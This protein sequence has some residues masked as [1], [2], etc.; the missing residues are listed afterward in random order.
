MA[1]VTEELIVLFKS[2]GVGAAAADMEKMALGSGKAGAAS[3]AAA[4]EHKGFGSALSSVAGIAKTTAATFG[5]S[6]AVGIGESIK[7]AQEMQANLVQLGGAIKNNVQNP[8]KDATRQMER[9]ADS[10]AMRGGFAPTD[11]ILSMTKL[12]GVT[13]NVA[14]TEKDMSLASDIAR[15]THLGLAR[16]TRAVMMVEAGRTTGLSR[17][18]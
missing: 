14:E 2:V 9:F 4:V 10:L 17:L 7:K 3:K 6:L 11:A 16:A 18:G 15:R 13:K 12:L 5:I 1:T 8:S